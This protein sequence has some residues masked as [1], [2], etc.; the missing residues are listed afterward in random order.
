MKN[1]QLAA[2]LRLASSILE[3]GHPWEFR[4]A[5]DDEVEWRRAATGSIGE[6]LDMFTD[7]YE[8]RLALAT[9]GDGRKLH[10]PDN[11][12]AE[13]VGAGWRLLLEQEFQDKLHHSVVEFWNEESKKWKN[14]P[15][16]QFDYTGCSKQTYR[17]PLSTP[18]PEAKVD[19]YAEL[20]AAHKAGKVIQRRYDADSTRWWDINEP[21]LTWKW[22]VDTYRIKPDVKIIP[23]EAKDVPPGSALR[24][25]DWA[26]HNVYILPSVWSGRV[27]YSAGDDVNFETYD[28]LKLKGWQINKS[29]P[30]TGKWDADAWVKCEKEG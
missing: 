19:A 24:H 15:Y 8:I 10:N 17:L 29:I 21:S 20:K 14:R 25:P 7:G 4:R 1:E 23:L 30:I 27:S 22:P 5:G 2:Q 13:Q 9:P 12:T 18:W 28:G 16:P 3:T 26:K 11:L 6:I